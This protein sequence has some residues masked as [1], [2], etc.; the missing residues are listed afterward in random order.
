MR[1]LR[2]ARV[3]ANWH[4]KQRRK[5]AAAEPYV[6]HL[7]EVAEL[8]SMATVNEDVIC[9]AFLHDAIEDQKISAAEIGEA[10]GPNVAALVLEVTDD[11]SLSQVDRKAHQIAHA[12]SLSH[13]ARLIKLADKISNLRSVASSPPT[14]WSIERRLEYVE[15]CRKVEAGLRGTDVALEI[16]FGQAA[17]HAQAACEAVP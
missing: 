2:A 17:D 7:I 9:A 12:P 1:I 3:A 5:G 13:E 11:K 8:V 6:N 14:N 10:F 16:L 15:F 4:A